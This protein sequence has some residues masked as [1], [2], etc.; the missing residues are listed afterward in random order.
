MLKRNLNSIAKSFAKFGPYIFRDEKRHILATS[1]SCVKFDSDEDFNELETLLKN[2]KRLEIQ[3]KDMGEFADKLNNSSLYE[4]AD[5][6]FIDLMDN[7]KEL[8]VLKVHKGYALNLKGLEKE[9]IESI[10][11]VYEHSSSCLHI[12]NFEGFKYYIMP[13]ILS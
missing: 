9:K 1:F 4:V 5:Y 7:D 6:D 2:R 10:Y 13:R 11:K 12:V 8:R 3:D